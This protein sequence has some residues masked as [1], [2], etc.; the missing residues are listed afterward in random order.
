MPK[1]EIFQLRQNE[2]FEFSV[3]DKFWKKFS[4]QSYNALIC[5]NVIKVYE[6]EL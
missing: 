6:C 2:V 5:L 4:V 3:F 1:T